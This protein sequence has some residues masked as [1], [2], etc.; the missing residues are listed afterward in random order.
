MTLAGMS[1]AF[2][3]GLKITELSPSGATSTVAIGLNK[4]NQVVGNYTVS[5]ATVKGFRYSAGK[6]N[7]IVFPKSK[8]FTRANGISDTGEIAGDF[9]G[10]DNWYHGFTNISG[11]FTQYDLPGGLGNFS[12]SIFAVTNDG[13]TA[14]AAGGGTLGANNEGWVN[15]SGTVTTFYG[16]GTDNTFVLGINGSDEFVGQYYDS[17]NLS[18]GFSGTISGGVPTI[19]EITLSGRGSNRS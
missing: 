17:G 4:S 7:T 8:N 6:Y 14:G 16:S 5:G 2:A 3:Q 1:D 12:T 18:H 15:I 10:S 11:K 19:T 9:F 13:D